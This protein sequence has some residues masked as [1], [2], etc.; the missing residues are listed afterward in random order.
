MTKQYYHYCKESK[1]Q[2]FSMSIFFHYYK[3]QHEG[4]YP[5][6]VNKVVI[7]F[8]MEIMH[9][10]QANNF[11]CYLCMMIISQIMVKLDK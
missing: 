11:T 8:T 10:Q 1:V 9:K 4:K 2:I 6:L 3:I 7:V 5:M